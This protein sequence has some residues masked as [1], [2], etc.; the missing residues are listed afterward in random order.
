[1]GEGHHSDPNV[2]VDI[3]VHPSVAAVRDECVVAAFEFN[4]VSTA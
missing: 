1:M 3:S 4:H 2:A